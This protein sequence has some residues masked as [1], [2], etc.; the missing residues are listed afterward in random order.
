MAEVL[1][2]VLQRGGY[3]QEWSEQFKL[4]RW[5]EVLEQKSI[6]PCDYTKALDTGRSLPWEFISTGVSRD[7]LLKEYE[8]ALE[9]IVLAD[10]LTG[11]CNACGADCTSTASGAT[12]ETPFISNEKP[13]RRIRTTVAG[14]SHEYRVRIKFEAGEP[15]R[16][17][18]HLDLVRA[19]YRLLRRSGL[20]LSYSEGFSPHPRASF[21]FPKPVGVTSRGE[22]VDIFLAERPAKPIEEILAPHMPLGLRI[23]QSKILNASA[24]A[25]TK[26]ADMLHYEIS[27]SPQ[28]DETTLK[29]RAVEDEYVVR[30]D[31][32]DGHLTLF[33]DQAN[34]VKLWDSLANIYKIT[35]AQARLLRPERVDAYIKRG[36]GFS[37]LFEESF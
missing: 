33:L 15:F 22:Y 32:K 14:T 5:L 28:V 31:V 18:S 24:Q 7:F 23:L 9:G 10:C 21:G 12:A 13:S 20:T 34:R 36:Q 19:I 11:P 3:F 4:E 16:Y 1:E 29:Q 25:I 6:D 37:T 8:R 26:T 35:S 2:G 27:P 30:A 17:A